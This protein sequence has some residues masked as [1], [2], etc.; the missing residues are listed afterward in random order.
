MGAA[1][2]RPAMPDQPRLPPEGEPSRADF[3]SEA[4]EIFDALEPELRRLE[5]GLLAPPTARAP[6]PAV[7][8]RIFRGVHTLKG[9]SGMHECQAIADLAH[10]LED[11]LDR[12]RTGRLTLDGPALDL[13]HRGVAGLRARLRDVARGT[14]AGR[15]DDAL[16]RAL[17]GRADGETG[18][19]PPEDPLPAGLDPR[20]RAALSQYEER[21]LTEALRPGGMSVFMVRLRL[22][23]AM[24]DTQLRERVRAIEAHGEVICTMPAPDDRGGDGV[25][26]ILLVAV[27]DRGTLEAALS[28]VPGEIEPILGMAASPGSPAPSPDDDEQELGGF[29]GSL[30][31][32]VSRLDELMAEVGEVAVA[33]ST[34]AAA[35]RRLRETHPGDRAARELERLLRDLSP[36]VR[37]LQRATVGVRLVPLEQIFTRLG[38]MVARLARTAGKEVELRILGGETELDKALM[39][40][41][42][43]PLMHLLRNALDHGIEPG[44][45]RRA[46]GKPLRARLSLSAFR[47]GG[48][49]V[50]DVSDDGRGIDREAVRAAAQGRGLIGLGSGLP[51]ADLLEVIFLPGFSTASRVN[52]ISGRGVGLDVVRRS[53]HRLKGSLEVRSVAGE[54]MTFTLSLPVTLSLVQALIVSACGQRFA[55]PLASIAENL[56][57]RGVRT[58]REGTEEV[59]DRPAGPLRLLRLDRLLPGVGGRTSTPGRYVVVTGSARHPVGIVID[60]FVGQQEVVIKPVGRLLSD[61][62]GLAGATDLGDATAVLVLDPEGLFPGGENVGTAA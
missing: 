5:E 30:R 25:A 52:Q 60:E 56:P 34:L 3:L 59:L 61:L 2:R 62:R 14:A 36:R 26:F 10:D 9:L 11:L 44:E 27:P 49:V 8:N 19:A 13:I 40:R 38:R 1:E 53:I 6:L 45:A 32:S 22:D 50:I 29:S 42:A 41:I 54:G 7:I 15:D 47:K 28:G 31:V 33:V 51:E 12:L 58:R 18:P 16:R 57:L 35:A 43:A 24:F 39:D 55:I 37:S 48:R 4:E 23:A 21:R 20:I 46:A 17:R